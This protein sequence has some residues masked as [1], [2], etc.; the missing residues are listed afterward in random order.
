MKSEVAKKEKQ[1]VAL[2]DSYN[3]QETRNTCQNS[4]SPS[5]RE[6]KKSFEIQL[7]GDACC[8][9]DKD[10]N[11]QVDHGDDIIN[12]NIESPGKGPTKI[13]CSIH[14][15]VIEENK[16]LKRQLAKHRGPRYARATFCSDGNFLEDLEAA[17]LAEKNEKRKEREEKVKERERDDLLQ[18]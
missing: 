6:C 1:R 13:P 7:I 10:N 8:G 16:E 11:D 14:Q 5:A 3:S 18:I 17:E 9:H 4:G 12:L 15:G 2:F